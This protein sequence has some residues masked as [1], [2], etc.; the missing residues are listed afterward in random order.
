MRRLARR[1]DHDAA[2]RKTLAD[3]VV[4]LA[5]ELQRDAMRE[6]GAKALAGRALGVDVDGVVGQAGIAVD[7][8]DLAREHGADGAIDVA[9]RRC[10][11]A[12]GAALER[13]RAERAINSLVERL[14]ELVI[15]RAR[16]G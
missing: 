14:L 1:I 3:I 9:D 10:R 6:P 2:A 15:L 13:R 16:S 5:F 4:G 8:R 7:A 12:P 11:S